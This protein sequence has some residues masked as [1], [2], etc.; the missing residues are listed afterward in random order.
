MRQ[1]ACL[2]EA[3]RFRFFDLLPVGILAPDEGRDVLSGPDGV[4]GVFML[5]EE[6]VFSFGA[7]RAS[8]GVYA[9]GG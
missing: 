9:S 7:R 1:R 4:L 2:T 6:L 5:L 3:A 8:A